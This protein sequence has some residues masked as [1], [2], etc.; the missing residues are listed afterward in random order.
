VDVSKTNGY[1]FSGEFLRAGSLV[2]LPIGA[3][4]VSCDPT[5]SVKNG[6]KDGTVYR[7]RAAGDMT[8]SVPSCMDTLCHVSDWRTDFL[9]IRDAV[10]EGLA[11]AAVPPVEQAVTSPAAAAA[12]P[13]TRASLEAERQQLQARIAEIEALLNAGG[14][15][16]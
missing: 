13:E 6:G 10:V 3:I 9:Q 4:L 16:K 7:V 1:A 12:A 14:S 5:G 2:D 11:Q 8:E 15:S